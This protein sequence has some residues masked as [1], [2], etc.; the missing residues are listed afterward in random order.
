MVCNNILCEEWTDLVNDLL[1][2]ASSVGIGIYHI[3]GNLVWCNPT[4]CYYL[5]KD[6][7]T[8]EA[9]NYFVNPLFSSFLSEEEG[10]D[11]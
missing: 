2:Q 7:E 1:Q 11:L 8:G 10:V 6:P 4:M 9:R 3:D 5:D